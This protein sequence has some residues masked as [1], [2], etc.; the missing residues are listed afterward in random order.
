MLNSSERQTPPRLGV[1]KLGPWAMVHQMTE[2]MVTTDK[3]VA[4]FLE[5]VGGTLIFAGIEAAAEAIAV[6]ESGRKLTI[7]AVLF[8]LVR[9]YF[10]LGTFGRK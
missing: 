8:F 6:G 1:G 3:A 10:L 4:A 9:A 7:G 5:L 2:D